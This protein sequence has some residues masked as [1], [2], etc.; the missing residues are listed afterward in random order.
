MS[1]YI[2][3]DDGTGNV[4]TMLIADYLLLFPAAVIKTPSAN[5]SF[6]WNGVTTDYILGQPV[7]VAADQFA[8]MTAASLP[9][10]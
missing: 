2:I 4:Q 9:I 7:V 6:A 3:T 8:A 1:N 5:F 10:A